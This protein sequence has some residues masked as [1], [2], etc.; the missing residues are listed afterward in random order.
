[1]LCCLTELS[2]KHG[3]PEPYD[4]M[5]TA[6]NVAPRLRADGLSTWIFRPFISS[7][8]VPWKMAAMRVL[9][10]SQSMKAPNIKSHL[11]NPLL[12]IRKKYSVNELLY[13]KTIRNLKSLGY[14]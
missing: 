8:A 6:Q 14:L 2:I 9:K 4:R 7:P 5:I 13:R 11:R 12:K 3:T 1:M 10:A